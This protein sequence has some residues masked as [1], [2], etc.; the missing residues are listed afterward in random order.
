M[1][2]E[3]FDPHLYLAQKNLGNLEQDLA[4]TTR[5]YQAAINIGDE[6]LAEIKQRDMNKLM[7]ERDSLIGNAQKHMASK[8]PQQQYVPQVSKEQREQ[9]QPSEMDIYDV[10]KICGL[11]PP[12]L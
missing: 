2:D 7:V 10:S 1:A 6:G 9:R 11:D 5:E 12:D 8:Q 4:L 3:S